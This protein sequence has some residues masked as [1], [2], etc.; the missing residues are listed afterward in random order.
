L[1]VL[2][3]NE[4]RHDLY[5]VG[6]SRQRFATARAVVDKI[7]KDAEELQASA[8]WS[9]KESVFNDI[10]QSRRRAFYATPLYRMVSPFVDDYCTAIKRM[11][12]AMTSGEQL[13]DQ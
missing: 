1:E 3:F 5:R 2:A 11:A 9:G 7:D 10:T 12:P 13:V 8:S 6:C 4:F